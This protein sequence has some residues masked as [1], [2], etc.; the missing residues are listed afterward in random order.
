MTYRGLL[1]RR[2]GP[3]TVLGQNGKRILVNSLGIGMCRG[4]KSVRE[5]FPSLVLP[6]AGFI[7]VVK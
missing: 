1:L 7:I 6:A 5:I 4:K 3:S 2:L